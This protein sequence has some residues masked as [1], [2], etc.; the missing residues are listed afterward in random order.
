MATRYQ[1]LKVLLFL[2]RSSAT[3]RGLNRQS[4]HSACARHVFRMYLACICGRVDEGFLIKRRKLPEAPRKRCGRRRRLRIG[5]RKLPEGLRMTRKL[6]N[7]S[8]RLSEHSEAVLNRTFGVEI[9]KLLNVRCR[10]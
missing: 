9:L 1:I 6:P 7:G 8:Q 2:N 5:P 3:V 10:R 4:Y